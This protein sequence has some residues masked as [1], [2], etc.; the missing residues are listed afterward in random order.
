MKVYIREVQRAPWYFYVPVILIACLSWYEF[1]QQIIFRI[2]FG[3]TPASNTEI[4]IIWI[5]F[6]ILT[7]FIFLYMKLVTE[8]RED[9]IYV[10]FVPFVKRFFA[11]HE[12]KH[13]KACTYNPFVYGG[14]GI[15]WHPTKGWAYNMRGNKGILIEFKNGKQVLIGSEKSEEL[16]HYIK[17]D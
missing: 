12:I 13:V 11:Y 2:P 7:P 5:A 4:W 9:G 10:R 15:R 6:G 1:F 17:L 3:N 14:W 16:V 8:I